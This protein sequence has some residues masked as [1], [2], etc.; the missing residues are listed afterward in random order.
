MAAAG[1]G[2]G[3]AR[4]WGGGGGEKRRFRPFHAPFG[5]GMG[6]KGAV[7]APARALGPLQLRPRRGEEGEFG[8]GCEHTFVIYL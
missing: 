5:P 3:V 4:G 2:G 1:G 6:R 8:R 7:S